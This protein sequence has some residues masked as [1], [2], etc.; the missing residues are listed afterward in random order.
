MDVVLFRPPPGA[1]RAFDTAGDDDSPGCVVTP[2]LAAAFR[3][4][5]YR[6]VFR[7]T[8]PDGIVPSNPVPGGDWQGVYKLSLAERDWILEGGLAIGLVQFGVFG[9]ASYA[10]RNGMAAAKC[11]R[12]LGCPPGVTHFMD[13]EGGKPAAA[14]PAACRRYAETWAKHNNAGG[15]LTG[16]YRN[17]LVPLDSR[18]TY[19]LAGVTSYWTGWP[20][21]PNPLPR[22]ECVLQDFPTREHGIKIDPDTIITDGRGSGPVL[23]GTRDIVVQWYTDAMLGT[24]SAMSDY[25][26]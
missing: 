23:I 18:Q 5:G 2:E 11:A 6:A 15:D 13:V 24:A 4:D 8:A 1:W 7:Y 9:D 21:S 3:A 26:A 20:V 25:L 10:R 22:G 17:G 19:G 16:L 14:G 12:L